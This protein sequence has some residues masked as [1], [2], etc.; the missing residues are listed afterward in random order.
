MPIYPKF[1]MSFCIGSKNEERIEAF[2]MYQNAF[3]A[4]KTWEGTPPDGGD[5]HIT[6]SINGFE[7]LLG[8]G[9]KVN[10]ILENAM[11]CEIH[12]NNENDLHKAYNILQKDSLNNSLEGPY[13]WAK[14]LGL[15]I[16]KFGICWALYFNE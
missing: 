10:K 5:I 14:V 12:F 15:V 9:G 8:P 1:K 13:P 6:I 16:D 7:I 3:N 11:C 4:I 2:E